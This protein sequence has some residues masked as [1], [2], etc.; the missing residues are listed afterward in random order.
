MNEKEKDSDTRIY[1]LD[2]LRGLAALAVVAYHYT[3]GTLRQL[4]PGAQFVTLFFILSGLVL[5]IVPLRVGIDTYNWPRYQ[6]RRIAR[7]AIPT[8]TAIGIC[9]IVS[10]IAMHMGWKAEEYANAFS[11]SSPSAW[12]HNLLTQL[13]ML[14][15]TTAGTRVDGS[16][17]AMV[18]LPSW[19]MCWEL[20]F[21]LALPVYVI[22]ATDMRFVAPIALACVLLS[23]WTQW[24]PLRHMA[25]FALGVALAKRLTDNGRET[26]RDVVA[27]PLALC[28]I[29]LVC[30]SGF[31]LPK[32]FRFA[33]WYCRPTFGRVRMPDIGG[34]RTYLQRGI[35]PAF[36]ATCPL[37]GA[38]FIQPV[39]DPSSRPRLDCAVHS[40]AGSIAPGGFVCI[41]PSGS[42]GVLSCRGTA[43]YQTVKEAGKGE[44]GSLMY[45]ACAW[46]FRRNRRF[47]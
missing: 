4:L 6:L 46:C 30:Q 43:C 40:R 42:G 3:G 45:F 19:S 20:L 1:A 18:D 44:K 12:L 22:I 34:G 35:R 36:H 26:M 31:G 15:M 5:S 38:H 27:V 32:R 17:L 13:D 10:T 21:S 25:M 2:G 11:T 16:T 39:S 23:E 41:V 47:A 37:A 24:P 7:L 8:C 33:A 14:S 29:V 28:G 9:C